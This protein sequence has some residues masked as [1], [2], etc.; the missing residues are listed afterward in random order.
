M[1]PRKHIPCTRALVNFPPK[2]GSEERDMIVFPI[3]KVS[4]DKEKNVKS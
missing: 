1:T 4:K 3:N 2:K